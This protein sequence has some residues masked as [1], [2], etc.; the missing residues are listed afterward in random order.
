VKVSGPL[1]LF[2][3]GSVVRVVALPATAAAITGSDHA[4][5]FATALRDRPRFGTVT[6]FSF[7]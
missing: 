4:A 3:L 6:S 1:R 2:A 5:P 7:I